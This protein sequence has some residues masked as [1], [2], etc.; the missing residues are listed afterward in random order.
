[1][2][3]KLLYANSAAQETPLAA[4]TVVWSAR[5]RYWAVTVELCPLCGER[6]HHGGGD[7]SEP[8]LGD[9]VAHCNQHR[10]DYELVETA[11]SITARALPHNSGSVS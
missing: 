9:R 3:A 10:G 7:G 8:A 1:M 11:A 6:H 5:G 2:T 4:V